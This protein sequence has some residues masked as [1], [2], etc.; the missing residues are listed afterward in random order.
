MGID[1]SS[2]EKPHFGRCYHSD[3][4]E[5]KMAVVRV[6]A[7]GGFGEDEKVVVETVAGT[8]AVLPLFRWGLDGYRLQHVVHSGSVLQCPWV[9]GLYATVN[10]ELSE[11]TLV[12]LTDGITWSSATHMRWRDL[13]TWPAL[14]RK[15][16]GPT[17]HPFLPSLPPET[18]HPLPSWATNM[19]QAYPTGRSFSP[20]ERPKKGLLFA[21]PWM[22]AP[23]MVARVVDVPDDGP[24]GECVLEVRFGA[25]PFHR[26][27]IGNADLLDW[28]IVGG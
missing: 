23:P 22:S 14:D 13:V 17:L 28:P 1:L 21:V 4:V 25:S 12:R 8:Q 11:W 19:K 18:P 3:R 9:A 27:K 7:T 16:R 5:P 24:T 26:L 10:S 2:I 20:G 15:S 6:L